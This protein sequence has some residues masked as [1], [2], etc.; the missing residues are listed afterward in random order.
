MADDGSVITGLIQGLY[1]H[2]QAVESELKQLTDVDNTAVSVSGEGNFENFDISRN[3][4]LTYI[5]V[6]F[7][8][9]IQA[10]S[11]VRLEELLDEIEEPEKNQE[12]IKQKFGWFKEN[13]P[14]IYHTLASLSFASQL[15]LSP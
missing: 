3:K 15:G 5:S 6:K 1:E 14:L 13:I 2:Q 11:I 8:P 9:E 7:D 10:E 4:A 12:E